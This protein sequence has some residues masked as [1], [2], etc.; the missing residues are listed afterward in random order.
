MIIKDNKNKIRTCGQVIK[1]LYI[2][3]SLSTSKDRL[4]SFINEFKRIDS[5][6]I[7]I[8]ATDTDILRDFITGTLYLSTKKI[9]NIPIRTIV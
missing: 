4:K 2:M 5:V 7:K 9:N 6:I 8:T 3:F 1:I